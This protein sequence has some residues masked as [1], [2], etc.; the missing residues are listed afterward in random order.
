MAILLGVQAIGER[1]LSAERVQQLSRSR[2]R[3]VDAQEDELRR[4]ERDLH[5]GAQ[6]R[7]VSL[8]MSL[9]LAESRLDEDPARARELMGEAQDQTR[10][11]LKELRAP[12]RGIAPPVPQDRGLT[13]AIEALTATAAIP[14]EVRGDG[15]RA[16]APATSWPPRRSPTRPSTPARRPSETHVLG[17]VAEGRSN[18]GIAEALVVTP[19]AV[20]KHISRIFDKLG[21]PPSDADH[22]RVL[23]V[24][25]FL[26][27]H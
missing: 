16:P 27:H 12:A 2:A 6:A 8:A 23:A 18:Q 9:G 15:D 3:V 21:L 11:A 1:T 19:G 20:E 24:L 26:R 14:V 5:H 22:R 4:I 25:A 13:A 10:S 17:L 7:L